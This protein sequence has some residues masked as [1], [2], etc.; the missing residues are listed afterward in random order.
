[1][2][3]KRTVFRFLA[4]RLNLF[5]YGAI[6]AAL[7]WGVPFLSRG[8]GKTIKGGKRGVR[9]SRVVWEGGR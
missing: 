6:I 3:L 2:N 9:V 7:F 8:I 1:M 4:A 5:V